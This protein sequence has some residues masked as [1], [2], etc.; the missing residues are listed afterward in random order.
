M[1]QNARP[2]SS[3]SDMISRP[4][5]RRISVLSA[6]EAAPRDTR[7]EECEDSSGFSDLPRRNR[8]SRPIFIHSSWRASH[9]WFWQRFRKHQS[10]VCFYEPFHESLVTL[11]KSQALSMGPN[12]WNSGHPAGDPYMIEFL[13][14]IRRAGGVRLFTPEIS[15]EW[16]FPI[17]GPTGDLHP[18]ELRYLA[19]LIRHA[20]RLLRIPVFGFTRS[21]GRLIAIKNRFP[22][23]HIFQYR[24][25][26]TQ[27]TSWID[28][29]ENGNEYFLL[30][31]LRI[32]VEAQD[33]YLSSL[34]NRCLVSYIQFPKDEGDQN[35]AGRDDF[36]GQLTIKLLAFLSVQEL[37]VLYMAFHTYLYMLAQKSAD[38]VIDITKLARDEDYRRLAR[39]QLTS[40]TGLPITFDGITETQQYH[41]FDPALIDWR[42]IRDNLN[43]AVLTLDHLF[44]RQELLHYGSALLDETRA[45]IELSEKY[46]ARARQ[47]AA[48]LASER[49]SVA[50]VR[51]TLAAERDRLSAE[52]D[53]AF[54]ER[55]RLSAERDAAFAERDRLSAERDAAFAER[56][57]L[58]AERDAAFAERDRLLAERD[59][60]FAERD[61]FSVERDAAFAERDRL[62]AERDAAVAKRDRLS[63]EQDAAFAERY[64]LSAERDAA[65]AERDRLS[66]QSERWFNAAVVWAADRLL[67]APRSQRAQWFCR[68]MLGFRAGPIGWL[69]NGVNVRGSPRSRADRA[70]DAGEW[71]LAARFYIDE[72]NRNVCDPSL[73]LELAHALKEAGEIPAAEIA[74]CKAATLSGDHKETRQCTMQIPPN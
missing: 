18:K 44:D 73:W 21:L 10:T 52:R 46:V 42:S 19:L 9:T 38:I 63:A 65:V 30:N 6:A 1:D 53:A 34:I 69:G 11:T 62:S 29:R 67:S 49:D 20:E 72:L 56:D 3:E 12:S 58:S 43:F 40:A 31:F 50:A 70:R 64:R 71:E 4:D 55:D 23:T 39:D 17:G 5:A 37:F 54:A 47:R 28:H 25:L 68:L 13:P 8:P 35:I 66:A 2:W 15:Y 60:A 22:G 74:Y 61:R 26:W 7:L 24:N 27:W 16:F 33:L 41:P 14:L 36:H 48:D 32:M 45:E 51:S 57:R 59:A